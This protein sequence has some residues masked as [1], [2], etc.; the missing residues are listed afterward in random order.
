MINK[1]LIYDVGMHKG[2]DTH[3]YLSKG[4]SVIA[5]EADPDLIKLAKKKFYN[6][7]NKQ[8]LIIVEGAI[9]PENFSNKVQFYK[10]KKKTIW[11]TVVENWAKRNK[12]SFDSESISIQVNSINFKEILNKYGVPYY[13][14]IDIEGMDLVCC[15]AL[16]SFNDKPSFIS[17]ESEK[18]SFEKLKYEINLFEKL[19]Y[20]NYKIIQQ[21]SV[22][23]QKEKF[24]SKEKKYL[25]YKFTVGSSGLFGEDLP[26]KWLNKKDTLAKYKKIFLLYK[27]F[28]DNS[29]LRRNILTKHFFIFFTK[30]IYKLTNVSIPGWYDTHAKHKSF[31]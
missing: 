30:I 13:L 27:I 24:P 10:N 20:N 8:K 16:L 9:V 5:F 17:I 19:G 26:S 15:E 28:G 12:E 18:I 31:K 1:N 11:G 29:F 7:I 25:G 21:G 2:E 14:K 3:Y 6:E 23:Q 22:N 4:F